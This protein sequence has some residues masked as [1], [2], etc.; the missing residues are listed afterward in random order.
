MYV[1]SYFV[2]P[3][4]LE[5]VGDHRDSHVDQVGGGNLKD[6]LGELFAVLV[7]FL[8]CRSREDG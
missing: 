5:R 6:L 1:F 3:N 8:K 2:V 4:V 7:D